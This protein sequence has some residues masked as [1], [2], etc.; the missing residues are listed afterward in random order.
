ME[1]SVPELFAILDHAVSTTTEH[2]AEEVTK[3][4]AQAVSDTLTS[5]RQAL[6]RAVVEHQVPQ[7]DVVYTGRFWRER[8]AQLEAANRELGER[9]IEVQ[10]QLAERKKVTDSP[11]NRQ[12]VIDSAVRQV[13]ALVAAAGEVLDAHSIVTTNSVMQQA[14]L[15]RLLPVVVTLADFLSVDVPDHIAVAAQSTDKGTR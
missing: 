3:D 15:T 5:A 6:Q 14:F 9:I 11:A 10:R 13:E 1:I 12:E 8:C 2:A 4:V 7:A